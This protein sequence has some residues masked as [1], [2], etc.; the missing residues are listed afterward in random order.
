MGEEKKQFLVDSEFDQ[1]RRPLL[2]I[3]HLTQR[4]GVWRRSEN[5]LFYLIF[6]SL[7]YG[8]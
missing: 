6:F 3:L 7:I 2:A 4:F 5:L 8:R 1:S